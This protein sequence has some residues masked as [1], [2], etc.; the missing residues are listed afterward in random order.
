MCVHACKYVRL[1][2]Y[3]MMTYPVV[4]THLHVN[5]VGQVDENQDHYQPSAKQKKP[6]KT[7]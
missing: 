3:V 2:H 4:R 5:V 6:R 1:L 7:R